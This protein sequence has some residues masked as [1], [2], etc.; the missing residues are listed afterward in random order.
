LFGGGV[1]ELPRSSKPE[2]ST[3]LE[4]DLFGIIQVFLRFH[5]AMEP[6]PV[7]KYSPQ[8]TH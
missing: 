4:A 3:I 5:E 2:A 1:T 6:S 8:G 7:E